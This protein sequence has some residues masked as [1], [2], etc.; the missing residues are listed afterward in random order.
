[1]IWPIV[2]DTKFGQTVSLNSPMLGTAVE[3][4]IFHGLTSNFRFGQTKRKSVAWRQVVYIILRLCCYKHE[5]T[6]ALTNR[7]ILYTLE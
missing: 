7:Y 6:N 3:T 1:M 2:C 5:R 4:W